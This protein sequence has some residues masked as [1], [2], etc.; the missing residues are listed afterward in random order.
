MQMSVVLDVGPVVYTVGFIELLFLFK[1]SSK[2][3]KIAYFEAKMYALK[4]K[5]TFISLFPL[6][7]TLK[8]TETLI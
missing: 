4:P 2:I 6:L 8:S 3:A 5:L 7:W 1:V